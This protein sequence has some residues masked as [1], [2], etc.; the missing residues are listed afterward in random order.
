MKLIDKDEVLA[1]IKNVAES[2]PLYVTIAEKD[3]FK[4]GVKDALESVLKLEVKAKIEESEPTH[5]ATSEQNED[6]EQYARNEADKF[7]SK[8]YEYYNDIG[9]LKKGLREKIAV[10]A[11]NEWCRCFKCDG[12]VNATGSTCEKDKLL[13]CRKWYDGYRTALLAIS[14]YEQQMMAKELHKITNRV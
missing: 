7:A 12:K 6:I 3:A 2:N 13:T 5:F 9:L 14:D 11:A 1:A 4:D 10:N 8:E